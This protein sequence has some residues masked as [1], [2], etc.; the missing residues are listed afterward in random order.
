MTTRIMPNAAPGGPLDLFGD[1]KPA[2]QTPKAKPKTRRVFDPSEADA[3]YGFEVT[4]YSPQTIATALLAC[5][6]S[7][8]RWD[9]LAFMRKTKPMKVAPHPYQLRQAALACADLAVKAGW[10]GVRIEEIL[11]R[12]T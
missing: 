8:L 3:F 9:E 10:K 12:A 7:G 1:G 6:H 2:R 5:G 4:G 11:R